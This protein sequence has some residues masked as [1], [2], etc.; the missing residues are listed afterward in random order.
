MYS[1]I[2]YGNMIA[3]GERLH[4]Y[5]KAIASAVRTGDAV[6]EIGCGPGI[7]ALL[8]CQAGARRVYAIDS[9]PVVDLAVS[10]VVPVARD[11][12]RVRRK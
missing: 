2:E 1:L 12:A 9:E 10:N 3:D 11:V 6:A 4:A 7:F 5:Q 8:A